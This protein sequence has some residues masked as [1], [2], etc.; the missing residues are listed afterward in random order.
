MKKTVGIILDEMIVGKGSKTIKKYNY[1]SLGQKSFDL[2]Y[3]VTFRLI[4]RHGDDIK[5]VT[6]RYIINTKVIKQVITTESSITFPEVLVEYGRKVKIQ[7][8]KIG[9]QLRFN[10]TNDMKIGV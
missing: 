8:K 4:L 7:F 5:D 6:N 2:D 1:Q 9:P 3:Y 10:F